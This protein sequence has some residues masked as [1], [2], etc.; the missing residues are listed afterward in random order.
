MQIRQPLPN[1]L[2]FNVLKSLYF[3]HVL[4]ILWGNG[5]YV[6]QVILQRVIVLNGICCPSKRRKSLKL[7]ITT[8]ITKSFCESS[9]SLHYNEIHIVRRLLQIL[10]WVV[11]HHFETPFRR[12]LRFRNLNSRAI[13]STWKVTPPRVSFSCI[14]I[15]NMTID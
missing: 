6:V 4:H 5:L 10:C 14:C 8:F 3:L 9:G 12:I 15:K 11:F 2:C 7:N 13:S 1:N